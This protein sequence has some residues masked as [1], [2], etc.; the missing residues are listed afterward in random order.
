MY[1]RMQELSSEQTTKIHDASMAILQK[2]GIVVNEEEALEIFKKNGFKVENKTVFPTE[3][4]IENALSTAPASFTV[5]ARN[6]A[7]NVV[8]GGDDYVFLPG[9][10]AP[11]IIDGAGVQREARMEIGR[12]HV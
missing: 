11:Y 10:G 7:K 4:Q 5:H 1:D 2:T 9:Y 6:P 12:A 8:V 3:K